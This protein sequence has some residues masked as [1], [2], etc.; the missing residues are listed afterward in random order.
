M[1]SLEM[2]KQHFIF[3]FW[4]CLMVWI[5]DTWYQSL[6]ENL[7]CVWKGRLLL[8]LVSNFS[9]QLA[10]IAIVQ[11]QM[12]D[13]VIAIVQKQSKEFLGGCVKDDL[14]RIDWRTGIPPAL[15]HSTGWTKHVEEITAGATTVLSM[16]TFSVFL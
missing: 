15:K 6:R 2:I 10:V 11:E 5:K 14:I 13:L 3:L 16:R 4:L 7:G 8:R 9:V 1:Y 12:I